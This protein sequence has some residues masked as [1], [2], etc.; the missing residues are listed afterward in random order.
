MLLVGQV[1]KRLI[2]LNYLNICSNFH[3][4]DKGNFDSKWPM[5]RPLIMR[6]LRQE[7]VQRKEWVDLFS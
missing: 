6:L 7:N 1:N 5:I 3:L 4:K 2:E